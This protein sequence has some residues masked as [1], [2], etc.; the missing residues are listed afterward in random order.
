MSLD[1]DP[2]VYQAPNLVRRILSLFVNVRPGSDL[3]NFQ[4]SIVQNLN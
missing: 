4:A 1:E 3:T 2:D